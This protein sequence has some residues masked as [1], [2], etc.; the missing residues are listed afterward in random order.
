MPVTLYK[1]GSIWHYRG[2]VD[3]KRLRG[4]TATADRKI[5]E[6]IAH[7]IEGRAWKRR[8][9]GPESVTR[10]SDCVAL[11]HA[12]GKPTGRFVMRLLDYWRETPI[13]DITASAVRRS[14]KI[15]YPEGSNATWVRQVIV[16]TMAIVNHYYEATDSNTRLKVRRPEVV[17]NLR[18]A[19]PWMWVAA[20]Q[21]TASPEMGALACFLFTTGAR[22]SEALSVHWT[23]VDFGARTVRVR[24]PKTG[25]N[26]R[27]AN[28]PMELVTALANLPGEREGRIWKNW[29]SRKSVYKAWRAT[30]ERAGIP[31]LSPHCLRHGFATS[32]LHKGVDVRT[33]AH[34]G[35]WKDASTVLKTYAHAMK[36]PRITD[37]LTE[38]EN[39]RASPSANRDDFPM[40]GKARMD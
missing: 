2:T 20:F 18:S 35:G 32:L 19:A 5:A 13:Q 1:R 9:D 24:Q 31:Y 40:A 36:D 34:L 30:C 22:I 23:E 8:L 25:G 14:C 10:F 28:M 16:P 3:G 21:S 15:L 33:V 27:L 6:R 11:Y 4:S 37:R 38:S 17:P 39:A 12:D 7:E 26:E 29:S